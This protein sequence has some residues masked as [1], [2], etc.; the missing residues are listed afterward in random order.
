MPRTKTP[1]TRLRD[2][3]EFCE[4]L[5][6]KSHEMIGFRC[7]ARESSIH[8]T[9]DCFRR[10]L[11]KH[12]GLNALRTERY[13]DSMFCYVQIRSVQVVTVLLAEQ[14]EQLRLSTLAAQSFIAGAM[15][16]SM[17]APGRQLLLTAKD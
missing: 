8:V 7:C 10:L 13:D 4:D 12:G 3:S 6:I 9:L 5:R 11:L 1:A 14:V 15:P 17:H 2:A 16:V